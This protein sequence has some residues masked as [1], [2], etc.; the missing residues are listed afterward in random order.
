MDREADEAR[1][2]QQSL[3]PR[4]SPFIPGFA[5]TGV[6]VPAGAVGGD[7]YDF[8]PLDDGRWGLVLADVSGKGTGAAL[9]M[10]ATRGMIRSLA[11]CCGPAN[12]L[13]KLNRLLVEDFP[14]GRFVTMIYAVL[15]PATRTLIFASA[16][17]LPPLLLDGN[18]ARFLETEKG[19]PLGLGYGEYSEREINLS[20]DSRLLFYS[21]G[22]TEASN[23]QQ[24]EFGAQRL[25]T[26]A[27]DRD[28]CPE[29]ILDTV[30]AFASGVLQDDA[31]AILIKA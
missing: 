8:I 23:A 26:H 9:L 2:I 17:H 28:A 29:G 11:T 21:D 27:Q 5:V 19:I 14:C 18:G 20:P 12:V 3:L 30:R 13:T 7:W 10:S 31:T 24:E 1:Q 6:S 16:G 15:D 25:R 22:I 4:S